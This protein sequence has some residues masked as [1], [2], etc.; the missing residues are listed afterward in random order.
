[1]WNSAP[2]SS[3]HSQSG[4]SLIQLSL[5]MT[6]AGLIMVAML[7]G[8]EGSSYLSRMQVSHDRMM[9]IEKAS[10]GYMAT[11]GHR[12]CPADATVDLGAATFGREAANAGSCIGGTP[13]ANFDGTDA[14]A[15]VVAGGVPNVALGLPDEY[16]F[17]GFGNRFTYVADRRATAKTSCLALQGGSKPKPGNTGDI[18]IRDAASS[19]NL[20][21]NTMW[22]LISHGQDAHGA[23]PMEGQGA[24]GG[25]SLANRL[26]TGNSDADTLKN[27]SVDG[28]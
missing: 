24:T 22:A 23:F 27:A 28:P 14:N 3:A 10:E 25:G 18:E 7:P 13:A 19:G 17:D 20:L 21:S 2:T 11:Y 4:F 15:N 26:N 9:R 1:M 16:A 8:G 5:L 6:A 12:P